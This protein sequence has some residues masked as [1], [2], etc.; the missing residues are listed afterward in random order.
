MSNYLRHRPRL[1][2]MTAPTDGAPTPTPGP[3]IPTPTP[4]PAPAAPAQDPTDWKAEA[5]KWEARAKENTTAADELATLK[6]A[7]MTDTE[8]TAARLV[9][10]EAKVQGYQAKEQI[11]AWKATVSSDT[12]VPAAV[13]AGKTLEEIQAHAEALKPLIGTTPTLPPVPRGPI[14]PTEGTGSGGQGI[15]QL[16]EQDLKTMTPAQINQARR[17]GRLAKLMGGL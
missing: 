9:D 3:P 6:A 12:G 13:L 8:K 5:R 15:T 17:E 2:F 14:V 7:Q 1:R 10:L 4:T 16:T 11:D